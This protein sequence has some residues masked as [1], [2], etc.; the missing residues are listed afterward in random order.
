MAMSSTCSPG[1]TQLGRTHGAQRA[2][3]MPGCRSCSMPP[4]APQSA[5]TWARRQ[6]AAAAGRMLRCLQLRLQQRLCSRSMLAGTG[7]HALP[8]GKPANCAPC[9][10]VATPQ[11]LQRA[12]RST[13]RAASR[14]VAAQH[15]KV[16]LFI[17]RQQVL[18][19]NEQVHANTSSHRV[20]APA[21]AHRATIVPTGLQQLCGGRWGQGKRM[22]SEWPPAL[23]G[24]ALSAIKNKSITPFKKFDLSSILPRSVLQS[25]FCRRRHRPG[26]FP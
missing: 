4:S 17:E 19:G 18:E 12:A 2:V 6:C 22:K 14:M 8:G 20:P 16:A 11:V 26:G 25:T 10:T 9:V 3:T 15:G 23:A 5:C 7:Q 24:P 13:A 1:P 21:A